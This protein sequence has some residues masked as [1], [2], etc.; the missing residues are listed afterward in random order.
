MTSNIAHKLWTDITLSTEEMDQYFELDRQL[1]LM[2]NPEGILAIKVG[3]IAWFHNTQRLATAHSLGMM[4]DYLRGLISFNRITGLVRVKGLTESDNDT[5]EEIKDTDP[6]WDVYVAM[7]KPSQIRAELL[8]IDHNFL[9]EGAYCRVSYKINDKRISSLWADPQFSG[10]SVALAKFNQQSGLIE[11]KGLNFNLS[12]KPSHDGQEL[13][14]WEDFKEWRAK[15]KNSAFINNVW[16]PLE[17]IR[18]AEFGAMKKDDITGIVSTAIKRHYKLIALFRSLS[19]YMSKDSDAQ[20][21]ME[22]EEFDYGLNPFAVIK[23]RLGEVTGFDGCRPLEIA[24]LN[25]MLGSNWMEYFDEITEKLSKLVEMFCPEAPHIAQ[26]LLE[27]HQGISVQFDAD[28][29]C[30]FLYHYEARKDPYLN[31]NVWA[32]DSSDSEDQMSEDD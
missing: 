32:L 28:N 23:A 1:D 10:K 29:F 25:M 20:K 5:R 22:D 26:Y 4:P 11:F 17:T 8:E 3:R 31:G 19:R 6:E 30:P 14:L 27:K 15:Y 16:Q 21:E 9:L 12:P 7:S 2:A 18:N 13:K 24:Y